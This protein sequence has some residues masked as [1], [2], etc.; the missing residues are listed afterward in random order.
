MTVGIGRGGR[1]AQIVGNAVLLLGVFL[2]VMPFVY[3]VCAS[4]KPGNELFSFPVRILPDSL[5]WGNYRLLFEETSFVRW[6]GNSVFVA[7]ARTILAIALSLMAGYA[8]AKFEFPF[9]RLLFLLVLGT[10]TL[11]L[12]VILVP[13]FGLMTDLGWTDTYWALILPFT[14]QAIGIFLA[15]QQLLGIPNELLEAA[16]IDGAGEW[17]IFTRVV[18]PLAQPIIAVMGILFF[19]ASWNDYLWPLIMITSDDKFTVSVGLPTLV[20]PYSQEY[21]A[22]MAG[23]FMGTLPIVLIFLLFQRRFIEGIMAGAVKG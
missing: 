20:G 2:T 6:F 8:F 1:L 16:R 14:A 3:M 21:G 18:L 15:R 17:A 19:T 11:P 5:Y 23:S 12:Y 22:V 10:L 7:L 4:F 13:L 9:K